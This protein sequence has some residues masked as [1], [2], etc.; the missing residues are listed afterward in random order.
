VADL[1]VELTLGAWLA[2]HEAPAR[3]RVL[4][5]ACGDGVFLAA[6]RDRLGARPGALAGVDLCAEAVE[7]A[8]QA[9]GPGVTLATGNALLDPDRDP[10]DLAPMDP[11]ALLPG[12][13]RTIGFDVV[14]GNPPWV[15][16]SELARTSPGLRE[17]LTGRYATARG[18]WDLCCLFVE[19]A[20]S[21]LGADGRLGLVLPGAVL[22]A[23]YARVTRSLLATLDVEWLVD[24]RTLGGFRASAY[25]VLVV[26]RR[27][28]RADPVTHLARA[29]R[30]GERIRLEP[31]GDL[32]G[33][34]G[35]ATWPVGEAPRAT[36]AALRPLGDL[37]R[38]H[39][40]ATV[41]EAYLL[42]PLIHEAAGPEDPGFRLVNTGTLA[43]FRS[44]WGEATCRYLGARHERPVVDRT[45]LA[46]LLP[47][48]A[49][50]A[51]LPK[52]IVGGLSRRLVA[53]L[54]PGG[55]LPG[56]ST[57]VIRTDDEELAL[58]ILAL[59]CSARATAQY[60]AQ[61]GALALRGGYLRVG[62]PQLRA[63]LLPDPDALPT[64]TRQ[65]LVA[66]ARRAAG[67][68]VAARELAMQEIDGLVDRC[69]PRPHVAG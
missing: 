30:D 46:T 9:L 64:P 2:D 57:S 16:A 3:P 67:P 20:A 4:D 6:A 49:E 8:G 5:P 14:V 12:S 35:R 63:L 24:G 54:D 42:A 31:T 13:D 27:T 7:R 19:R 33:L 51:A 29:V 65:R 66:A 39:G 68:D 18:N 21:L 32:P 11:R 23:G 50:Q 62:P 25:P 38:V 55:L 40:A 17:R 56:K 10:P 1:L 47:R 61:F 48:R 34:A 60:A 69:W 26:A 44:R 58:A 52:L 41:R 45:D 59:L 43:P 22:A 37:A 15:D 36:T 53:V 28:S